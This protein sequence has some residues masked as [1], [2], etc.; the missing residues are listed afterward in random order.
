LGDDAR[1]PG[2]QGEEI[3]KGIYSINEPL[4]AIDDDKSSDGTFLVGLKISM[5]AK[6]H[7][8]YDE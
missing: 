4:L 8:M 6:R 7:H 5:L 1:F 2:S 3:R